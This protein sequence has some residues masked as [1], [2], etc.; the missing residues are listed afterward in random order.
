MQA[1]APFQRG[2]GGVGQPVV[3][4]VPHQDMFETGGDALVDRDVAA[5][6]G[7]RCANPVDRRQRRD[8]GIDPGEDE[9]QFAE[10]LERWRVRVPR[11]RNRTAE[12]AGNKV[13]RQV[14]APGPVGSEGRRVDHDQV[15]PRGQRVGEGGFPDAER[16]I[17]GKHDV[18]TLDQPREDRFARGRCGIEANGGAA[19]REKGVPEG[20]RGHVAV[21]M[22]PARPQRIAVRWFR[23][24][25]IGPE[26]RQQLGAVDRPFVREVEHAQFSERAGLFWHGTPP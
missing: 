5:L 13:G 2:P 15:G 11:G 6:S 23:A 17:A 20:T 22:R 3:V 21:D 19:R 25:D 26:V 8:R 1:A 10:R 7:A 4:P 18:G 16:A 14:V 12:R 9:V 24:D